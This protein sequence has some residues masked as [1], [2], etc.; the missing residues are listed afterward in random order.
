MLKENDGAGWVADSR[1]TAGLTTT[2]QLIGI[3]D[4]LKKNS[5]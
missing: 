4:Q 2:N 5:L 1:L 3:E